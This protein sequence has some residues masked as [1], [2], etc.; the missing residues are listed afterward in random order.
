MYMLRTA[1]GGTSDPEVCNKLSGYVS[2][3]DVLSLLTEGTVPF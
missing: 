2:P 3:G 1:I